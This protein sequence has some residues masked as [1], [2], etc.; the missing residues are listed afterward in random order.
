MQEEK[1]PQHTVCCRE[2][3][4]ISAV[5]KGQGTPFRKNLHE[6]HPLEPQGPS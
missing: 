6:V 1:P 3:E 5:A 2:R 4:E